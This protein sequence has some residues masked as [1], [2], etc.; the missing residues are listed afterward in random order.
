MAYTVKV[1]TL[2]GSPMIAE[3]LC[4]FHGRFELLVERDEHGD[5]PATVVCEAHEEL[6][7]IDTESGECETVMCCLEA[8]LVIS[9]P[10]VALWLNGIRAIDRASKSDEKD[11]RALDT[12]PL[13][14][15]KMT[16]AEWLRYQRG[17]TQ[18]R[19][20]QKRLRSGRISKRIQVG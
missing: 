4:P 7:S 6:D 14:T 13:A 8:E 15:G 5:P 18:E 11:P 16:K 3:Y 17:I 19:R 20:Y 9:A 10:A 12:E 2:P 1:R